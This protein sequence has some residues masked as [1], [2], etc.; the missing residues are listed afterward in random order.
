MA[1]SLFVSTNEKSDLTANEH[2]PALPPGSQHNTV[3]PFP[4]KSLLA[5]YLLWFP[6]GLLGLHR[7]YLHY[8]FMGFVYIFTL[9]YGGI[10]WLVD[11]FFLPRMVKERNEWLKHVADHPDEIKTAYACGEDGCKLGPGIIHY[12][13]LR[14]AYIL[15]L[16]PLGILGKDCIISSM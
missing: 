3:Q 2:P 1:T 12:R 8:N 16:H 15:T 10:G 4:Q 5:A 6:F 9:G 11:G 14:D 7:F 13:S